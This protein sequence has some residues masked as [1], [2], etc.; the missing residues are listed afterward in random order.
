M[1]LDN[2]GY[3]MLKIIKSCWILQFW[4]KGYLWEFI[5]HTSM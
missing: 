4:A 3:E 5:L 1:Y 2:L